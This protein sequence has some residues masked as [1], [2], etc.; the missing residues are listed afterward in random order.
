MADECDIASAEIEQ[1]LAAHIKMSLAATNR[2]MARKDGLCVNDCGEAAQLIERT[3]EDAARN[4][5]GSA[6][7]IETR[8]EQVKKL[9]AKKQA[10]TSLV[11]STFCSADCAF[12]YEHRVVRQRKSGTLEH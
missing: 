10:A 6:K 9:S 1:V 7:E 8:L 4:L 2:V 3:P 11:P 12:D 5:Q